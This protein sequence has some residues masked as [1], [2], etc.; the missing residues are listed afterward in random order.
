MLIEGTNVLCTGP[1]R[2]GIAGSG[3]G[4]FVGDAAIPKLGDSVAT[5]YDGEFDG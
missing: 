3:E 4:S 1:G 2:R 5:R